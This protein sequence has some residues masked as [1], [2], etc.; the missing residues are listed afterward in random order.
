MKEEIKRILASHG[1]DPENLISI[2]QGI[3]E[4][5]GYI[6]EEAV[7]ILSRELNYPE[8]GIYGVATFYTQFKFTK[9]GKH[10]IKVC[11]GTACHV[12]GGEN[13]LTTLENELGIKQGETTRDEEFSLER[14]ACMG[15]CALAP[16]VV[17]DDE[18]HSTMTPAK[19]SKTIDSVSLSGPQGG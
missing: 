19:L 16:V 6:S 15:C 18:V 9:T 8:S 17:V 14:V 2:L 10:L 13:L 3:Q 5:Y 4:R 7:F 1:N 12:K 11:L